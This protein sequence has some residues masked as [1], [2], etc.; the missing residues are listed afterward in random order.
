MSATAP[1]AQPAIV[2]PPPTAA[3]PANPVEPD[4]QIWGLSVEQYH[5]MIRSG[6]LDEDDP[7]ELLEG[8]LVTKMSKN[9]AHIAAKR[10][11]REA[12]Q[13]LIPTGWFIDDQEPITTRD[14]EP[15]PDIIVLRGSARTY[16]R[17]H[18][19]PEDAAL[20]VEIADSSL[21]RDRGRKKRIYARARVATYWI[22]NLIDR[23]IE[24]YTEPSGPSDKPDYRN[25][26]D[27]QP[28]KSIPVIVGGNEVG[29]PNVADLLP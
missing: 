18:P 28:E 27:Y 29:R 8:L 1:A 17:R 5:Q 24:V 15:E 25:R 11:F 12:L 26:E 14:S 23:Q 19:E 7:V 21:R 22:V 13:H 4:E 2:L 20:V 16:L 3:P 10:L 6:I 9:Q